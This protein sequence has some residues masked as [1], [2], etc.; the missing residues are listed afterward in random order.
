MWCLSQWQNCG[1]PEPFQIVEL[2]PGRGT[3]S[4]DVIRTLA[5]LGFS[6]E[7]SLH[8]VEISPY[9]SDLQAKRLCVNY[10]EA[11]DSDSVPYYRTGKTISG[12][13]VYWYRSVD[14]IPKSFSIFLAHEFFDA[15]PIHK[16][17]KDDN[18]WH[19]VLIDV[20]TEKPESFRFVKSKPMTPMLGMFLTRPWMEKIQLNDHVE[21]S[22]DMEQVMETIAIHI[23]ENGGFGLIIDYGHCGEKQST[24]R[25][26]FFFLKA[27]MAKYIVVFFSL[28][29][30][31]QE[32]R[33]TRS[34]SRAWH[35]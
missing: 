15:L 3:L 17:Q 20:D 2:G 35:S 13:S 18:A 23:E 19:E 26:G 1:S 30:V 6:K 9:M 34:F 27:L 28:F 31:V 22:K 25:V 21:Y 10:T 16:F 29:A 4:C 32:P 5:E 14:K 33:A 24:F 8:L 7:F 11:L 12:I